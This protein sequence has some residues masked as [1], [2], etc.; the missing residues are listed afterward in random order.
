MDE[1]H[2]VSMLGQMRKNTTDPRTAL[3]VLFP[4]KWRFHQRPYGICKKARLVVKAVQF[5]A[6]TLC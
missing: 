4:F 2:F 1:G 3:P 6:I 5:G